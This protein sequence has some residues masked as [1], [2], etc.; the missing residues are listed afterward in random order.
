MS[1]SILF[2]YQF[3]DEEVIVFADHLMA[4]A[5]DN[6]SVLDLNPL[7]PCDLLLDSIDAQ[8]SRLQLQNEKHQD[9]SGGLSGCDEAPLSRRRSV[10]TSTPISC[11][12]PGPPETKGLAPGKT[13]LAVSQEAPP[14]PL[15]RGTRPGSAG[16]RREEEQEGAESRRE[17]CLWRL[18]RLL[19]ETCGAAGAGGATPPAPP[20][21]PDSV[22]TED[23]LSCFREEVVGFQG[24]EEEGDG[25]SVEG[26]E[27][28][29]TGGSSQRVREQRDAV[30]VTRGGQTVMAGE[31]RRGACI[32]H[33]P[34]LPQ[35]QTHGPSK[36]T[37]S[38]ERDSCDGHETEVRQGSVDSKAGQ[39]HQGS[40][41]SCDRISILSPPDTQ[42]SAQPCGNNAVGH[43]AKPENR[44]R[45]NKELSSEP[46]SLA[47]VPEGSLDTV[48]MDS[49]SVCT[50]QITQCICNRTGWH[51]FMQSIQ[52]MEGFCTDQRDYNTPTL[53][54]ASQLQVKLTWDRGGGSGLSWSVS[55]GMW[56]DQSMGGDDDDDDEE[57]TDEGHSSRRSNNRLKKTPEVQLEKMKSDWSRMEDLLSTLRHK[58]ET[59]DGKLKQR[60]GA[61]REAESSLSDAQQKAKKQ[62]GVVVSILERVEIE[63]QL[64]TTK[65]QLFA[66][67]RRSRDK[68]D[69]MQERLDEAGEDLQRAREDQGLLRSSCDAL[70][71]KQRQKQEL[72]ELGECTV[73]LGSLEKIVAQKDLQIIGAQEDQSTLRAARDRLQGELQ[74]MKLQ[75]CKALSRAQVQ[76]RKM[77]AEEKDLALKEQAEAFTRQLESAQISLKVRKALEEEKHTWEKENLA[78]LQQ[79]EDRKQAALDGAR[80]DLEEDRKQ[81]A[82]DGARR[83]LEEDRKQ[84]A[85]DGARRDLEE[86]RKQ[87][88]LDGARRDLEEDRKQAALDGARRDLEEDRKQAALDGARRDLEEERKNSKALQNHVAELKTKVEELEGECCFQRRKQDSA[89][90]MLH[91]SLAEE[92]RAE[93]LRQ[94][95]HMEQEFARKLWRLEQTGQLAE[96]EADRLRQVMAEREESHQRTTAGLEQQL[97]QVTQEVVAECQQLCLL[98][99]QRGSRGSRGSRGKPTQLPQSP[100]A[101]QATQY[102]QDLRMR[103]QNFI[104]RL[105]QELQSQKQNASKLKHAKEQELC[106]QREKMET[107]KQQAL[108]SL[109]ERLVQEH[110]EE[111]GSMKRRAGWGGGGVEACLRRQQQAKEQEVR[112][113]QSRVGQW[114]S[115]TASRLDAQFEEELT[116]ELER[117]RSETQEEKPDGAKRP[118]AKESG[119]GHQLVADPSFHTPRGPPRTPGPSDTASLKLLHHLR[120]RIRQLRAES[121]SGSPIPP[122]R[123]QSACHLS[124][125]YLGTVRPPPTPEDSYLGTVRPPPT[126]EDSYLGTV[127]PT[128]SL[129]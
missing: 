17:Q 51:S 113:V 22:C 40:Q 75:H 87:A 15:Q 45:L 12:D 63:R 49:D 126:P 64:D 120:S 97:R 35:P 98:V 71:E 29:W 58:C 56:Y 52:N 108:H 53:E 85:L 105:H 55:V 125:S 78:A 83:D 60:R 70:E 24:P 18:G 9:S 89:L 90:A 13:R 50:Q 111:L 47:G 27:G 1:I 28:W 57:D 100:T 31:W 19:G 72:V 92:R 65:G 109:Q 11:L 99:D 26:E 96:R 74:T 44:G 129:L 115:W 2:H 107:E 5:E 80:R 86:D 84:A 114:Q 116:A 67:Q 59:E 16:R 42:A 7:D 123:L 62:T 33:R 25:E 34:P 69:S 102:L 122:L 14:R 76:V 121:Q 36:R 37:S 10:T 20:L 39:R 106:I 66:E 79:M 128:P 91:S 81:A 119:G 6:R 46:R 104:D 73:R 48:S 124:G 41:K 82:L 21:Q 117:R 93:L 118:A 4:G 30:G 3:T 77:V 94:R 8:L 101:A 127:R 54:P 38:E 112:Q 88:A 43:V 103:L 68:L 95:E 61:L 32:L 23:L 110:V